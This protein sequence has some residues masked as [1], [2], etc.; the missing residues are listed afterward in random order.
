MTKDE[1]DRFD[2]RIRSVLGDAREE[3]PD[4]IWSGIERRLSAGEG[5]S[6]DTAGEIP[7]RKPH[8]VPIWIRI[9]SGTAAAAAIAAVMFVSGIFDDSISQKQYERMADADNPAE[10][11]IIG[12][13][14]GMA[15][16]PGLADINDEISRHV[17]AG[18]DINEKYPTEAFDAASTGNIPENDI[19]AVSGDPD[20]G[21]EDSGNSGT[22]TADTVPVNT[23]TA[24]GN[25]KD[26][27]TDNDNAGT[28]DASLGSDEAGW[29]KLLREEDK[30]KR[31]IRTS[32]TLSGN[33]ISNTNAAA[34][35]DVSAPMSH[36]PNRNSPKKDVISE[37]SE[38]SYSVPV[39]F[40]MGVKID[41]TERWALG[42][43]LN[44]SHL[45]RTFAGTFF[46]YEDG[47]LVSDNTYSNILNSQD[48]IGI[49]FNVYFSILKND[50]V[51]FYAY[52]GGSAEKCISNR[53]VMTAETAGIHHNEPVQGFQFSANAG[54]GMEFIIADTFGIYI[55]PSLRY[56]FPDARQPHSIR[57]DQPLMF[58]LELGFRIRL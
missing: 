4:G 25:D 55:D 8:I 35:R 3:I 41:F 34:D 1:E 22:A 50:L 52:A 15:G 31:K 21:T 9:L 39:S 45:R 24:D 29:E 12:H 2:A 56:Y 26:V 46:D 49:P 37:S 54:L 10:V 58:G 47:I 27:L 6:D 57:T 19:T 23:G 13:E 43:G 16:K 33:A 51:D 7:G 11:N 28:G 42:I 18:Q 48:Y 40:G 44:Y 32:F 14:D 5:H 17:P 38:S 20:P 36:R 53:Y 30:G